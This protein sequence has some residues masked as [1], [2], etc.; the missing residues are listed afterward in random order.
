MGSQ[1]K[2]NNDISSHAAPMSWHFESL[3]DPTKEQ[4]VTDLDLRCHIGPR[5]KIQ[6]SDS[7]NE[8]AVE[9]YKPMVKSDCKRALAIV[10]EA[11]AT[12]TPCPELSRR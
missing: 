2:A 7:R 4:E 6:R 8:A 11:V 12:C 1:R 9:E 10:R 5:Q 3:D